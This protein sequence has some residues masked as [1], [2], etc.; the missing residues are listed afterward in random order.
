MSGPCGGCRKVSVLRKE[1]GFC[2]H[3]KCKKEKHE[4]RICF[5][6]ERRISCPASPGGGRNGVVV[7]VVVVIVVIVDVGAVG[8]ILPLLLLLSCFCQLLVVLATAWYVH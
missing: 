3:E 5:D 4:L 7:A 6:S 1:L 8:V 2:W